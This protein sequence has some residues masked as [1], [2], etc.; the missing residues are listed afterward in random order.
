MTQGCSYVATL[1]WRTKS[2]WDFVPSFETFDRVGQGLSPRA[3]FAVLQQ[4]DVVVYCKL[5]L[6]LIS[7]DVPTESPLYRPV[8]RESRASSAARWS[9]DSVMVCRSERAAAGSAGLPAWTR[10]VS[11]LLGMRCMIP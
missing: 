2:R 8:S 7:A 5:F 10:L 1:G 11:L 9:S 3:G 6:I 4:S